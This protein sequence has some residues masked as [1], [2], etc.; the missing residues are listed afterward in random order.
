MGRCL[1]VATITEFLEW[2]V[3]A[4]MGGT[5]GCRGVRTVSMVAGVGAMTARRPVDKQKE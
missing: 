1:S 3:A 2:S 5:D 4:R